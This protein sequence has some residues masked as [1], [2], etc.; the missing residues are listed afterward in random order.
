MSDNKSNSPP[1]FSHN[2]VFYFDFSSDDY[3]EIDSVCP[4]ST[5]LGFSFVALSELPQDKFEVFLL[6]KT[7]T[8]TPEMEERYGVHD[9]ST[10]PSS[11]IVAVGF[12]SLEIEPENYKKVVEQ[13]RDFYQNEFPTASFTPVYNLKKTGNYTDKEAHDKIAELVEIDKI[14]KTKEMLEEKLIAPQ[15]TK[16]SHKI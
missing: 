2:V 12:T 10:S 8:H 6:V 15:S 9:W 11:G 16:A 3:N 5:V 13:W 7:T 4:Q 1:L 14:K